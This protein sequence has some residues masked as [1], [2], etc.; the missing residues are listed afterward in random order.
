MVLKGLLEDGQLI[1]QDGRKII[2]PRHFKGTEDFAH[3]DNTILMHPDFRLFV[4]VRGFKRAY[5]L[6]F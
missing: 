3:D 6:C 4:L 1:L 5:T 2:S